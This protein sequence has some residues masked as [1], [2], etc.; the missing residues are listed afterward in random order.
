MKELS[1]QALYPGLSIIECIKKDAAAGVYIATDRRGGKCLLKTLHIEAVREKSMLQRFRREA[2][3]LS[4][5]DHPHIIKIIDYGSNAGHLYIAF[6][7]YPGYNLRQV[8]ADRQLTD[9]E[10][11]QLAEQL[12]KGLSY[13]HQNKVIHRDIKPENILVN[14]AGQ[15]KIADFGLAQILNE[16]SIT[17]KSSIVGTP[18]YMSPEQ[19]HGDTLT[20]QSDLFSAGVLIYE[21]FSGR[22]PFIGK[23]IS[24]TIGNIVNL[25]EGQL[26]R[27]TADLP[28]AART[29]IQG[30]VRKDLQR[31]FGSAGEMLQELPGEIAGNQTYL[32]LTAVKRLQGRIFVMIITVVLSAVGLLWVQRYWSAEKH[33]LQPAE[34]DMATNPANLKKAPGLTASDSLTD[35]NKLMQP[36]AN[37]EEPSDARQSGN[38]FG[39]MIVVQDSLLPNSARGI[40]ETASAPMSGELMIHCRPWADIWIDG[41]KMETTPLQAPL[42]LPPGEFRLTLRHPQ[43]PPVER[44][45]RLVAGQ[46]LHM[47]VNM[48]TLFGFLDCRV[49]PWGEI[50]LNGDKIA[51][52]PLQK[53]ILL[54]PGEYSLQIRNPGFSVFRKAI[55]ISRQETLR[56]VHRFRPAGD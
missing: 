41:R 22:H 10:R 14:D 21:L 4:G 28:D 37:S 20:P 43:Y 40:P 56:V 25:D 23:D 32:D 2:R 1:P 45:I 33:N 49:Y 42:Q 8:I 19:I 16:D 24:E 17:Q 47:A 44:V 7:Y 52:T 34:S 30:A 35:Q 46:P 15:L 27:Q 39:K 6:E 50:H 31:R 54:A 29:L 5:L 53:A 26:A 51:E 13:A 9:Q 38:A 36:E 3:I 12:L 48:D 18:G 11:F 55:Q